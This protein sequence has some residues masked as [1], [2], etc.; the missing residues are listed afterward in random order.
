MPYPN[1]FSC[2]LK[3]PDAF[4]DPWARVKRKSASIGKTYSVIRGTLKS[5]GKMEDQA[6]RYPKSTWDASESKKHCKAHKGSYEADAQILEVD[7]LIAAKTEYDCECIKCGYVVKSEEHCNKLKCPKCGGQMRRKER[8]GP[9]QGSTEAGRMQLMSRLIN[10]PLM[11]APDKME[12]ILNIA[13]PLM[14][15]N[16]DVDW[17]KAAVKHHFSGRREAN[18][19]VAVIGVYDTLFYHGGGFLSYLFGGSSYEDIRAAFQLALADD[20]VKAIVLDVDSPGGEVSGVFDLVDE[21][22]RARGKKPI[23]AVANESMFS[24]AYAIASAADKIYVPRTGGAGSVGV[25]AVHADTSKMDEMMGV[26]YTSIYAGAKKDALSRHQPLSEEAFKDVKAEVDKIYDLFVET[27]ARNR[28]IPVDEVK[29]TEAA[30]YLGEE[31]IKVGLVDEV[32][33]WDSVLEALSLNDGGSIMPNKLETLK[34]QLDALLKDLSS[35]D[36]D[37][38][39]SLMGFSNEAALEAL[40][41]ETKTLQ[42]ELKAVKKRDADE[43]KAIR[44]EIE[45]DVHKKAGTDALKAEIAQLQKD[46]ADAKK[47]I[48]DA[49]KETLTERERNRKMELTAEV[50]SIGLP[51]DTAKRVEMIFALEKTQPDMAKDYIAQ[52]KKDAIL[53]KE[54][55][56][57][58]ELGSTGEGHAGEAGVELEAKVQELMKDGKMTEVEA[59]QKAAR[60]NPEL[61]KRYVQ[62][63]K[64]G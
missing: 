35:E 56:L 20:T 44:E 62:E 32:L 45:K 39:Y 7:A 57:L 4:K 36:R 53:V 60:D 14:G 6:F 9:G 46:V 34:G 23:V 29:A 3:N 8:P 42:T 48:A 16:V 26:V 54:A 15:L 13:G 1:E 64:G 10:V 30:T 37:G 25:I 11:I 61:Y 22:Y 17:T 63:R 38:L 19:G 27:V 28:S 2:R 12:L 55:N 59:R 52:M 47:A 5:S 50:Q 51:G 40:K 33:S 18:N 21:I 43:L 58:T 41:E 49:K 31:G 24:A